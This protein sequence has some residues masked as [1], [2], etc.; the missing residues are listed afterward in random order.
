MYASFFTES[1]TER[2]LVAHIAPGATLMKSAWVLTFSPVVS[3]SSAFLPPVAYALPQL[4]V[5]P[6]YYS[7]QQR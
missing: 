1:Q 6:P 2:M 7:T 5:V 3:A 4:H